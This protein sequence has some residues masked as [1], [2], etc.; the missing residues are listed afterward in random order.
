MSLTMIDGRFFLKRVNAFLTV[1]GHADDV[2]V[3]LQ[4]HL[5]Q[6]CLKATVF[7]YKD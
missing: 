6:L 7:H 5:N 1:S 3:L 4:K 2:T